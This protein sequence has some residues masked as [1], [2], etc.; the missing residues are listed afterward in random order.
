MTM[1]F[2]HARPALALLAVVALGACGKKEPPPPPPTPI[3]APTAVPTPVPFKVVSVDLGKSIGDD[4]KIKDA[5]T[6]FGPK[7]TIYAAVST[8]GVAAKATLKARWTYGA[9]GQLVNEEARDIAPTGPAVTEFHVAKAS[10]WPVGH[11]KVEVS[12]DGTV[13]ATKEFEVKK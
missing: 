3:P 1:K 4:K 11:Y 8:E 12:A 5:A 6:T 9:K 10:G 13:A 2:R 7:D